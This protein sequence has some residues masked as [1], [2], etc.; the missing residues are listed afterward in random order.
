LLE[1]LARQATRLMVSV[2]AGREILGFG[3]L[4]EG[5]RCAYLGPLAAESPAIAAELVHT[6]LAGA[7]RAGVFWDI[8]DPNTDAGA[9]AKSLGFVSQ[10][11]LLRMYRGPNA[12]P[13]DPQLQFGIADPAVG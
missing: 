10:R 6:L 11:P 2:G 3:M 12:V 7:G 13:G 5:V 9:L 8:P 4:R 1:A